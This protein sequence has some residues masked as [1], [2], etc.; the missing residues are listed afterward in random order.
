VVRYS[1]RAKVPMEIVALLAM[2]SAVYPS[3]ASL[4]HGQTTPRQSNRAFMGLMESL[5]LTLTEGMIM[6][7]VGHMRTVGLTVSAVPAF[8]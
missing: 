5:R 3:K 7:K 2:G 1:S 8:R 4:T 6:D